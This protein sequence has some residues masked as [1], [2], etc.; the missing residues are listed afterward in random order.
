VLQ[1][2]HESI[3]L[4]KKLDEKKGL[5]SDKR[6]TQ[7]EECQPAIQSFLSSMFM[8]FDFPSAEE[9]MQLFHNEVFKV[10]IS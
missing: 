4:S 1:R 5:H 6:L 8:I 7:Q 9:K 3:P 10:D 2:Y